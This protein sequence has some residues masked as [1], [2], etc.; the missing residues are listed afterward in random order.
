MSYFLHQKKHKY[1]LGLI[2]M[3]RELVFALYQ[4]QIVNTDDNDLHVG[5]FCGIID[6]IFNFDL[7]AH[8]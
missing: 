1:Q 5:R 2:H 6:N 4:Y 7:R 8:V 3:L